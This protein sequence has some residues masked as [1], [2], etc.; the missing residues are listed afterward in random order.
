MVQ[1]IT[2]WKTAALCAVL[3]SM[4]WCPPVYAGLDEHQAVLTMLQEAYGLYNT[5]VKGWVVAHAGI[6]YH[7]RILDQRKIATP[8]GDR[9]Y[10]LTGGDAPEE[11]AAHATAGLLGA[12]IGVDKG[13]SIQ[14]LASTQAL[15]FGG[16]GKAPV[17]FTFHQ[18]G[19]DAYFDWIIASGY[20]A[21]GHTSLSQTILLPSGKHVAERGSLT[22]GD[23]DFSVTVDTS[24][25]GVKVLP[26]IVTIT[27][28]GRS[29]KGRAETLMIPFD[30]KGLRYR[31]PKAFSGGC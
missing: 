15:P 26:L 29:R 16:W 25:T 18:F 19:P 22:T 1:Y 6:R 7:F 14:I 28:E 12:F 24:A 11:Q 8:Y 3:T 4:V 17:T 31:S 27:H 30:E 13:N 23:E 10:V 20:T 9:L 5:R 21:Q 2:L